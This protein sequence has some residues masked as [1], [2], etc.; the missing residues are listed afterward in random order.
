MLQF[1]VFVSEFFSVDAFSSSSITLGEISSLDHEIRNWINLFL[2]NEKTK[3]KE[4]GMSDGRDNIV[5]KH[6]FNKNKNGH[7]QVKETRA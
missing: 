7:R 6:I 1:E 2:W 5:R 3:T 4:V